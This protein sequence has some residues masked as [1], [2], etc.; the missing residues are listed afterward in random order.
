M[1]LEILLQLV[2]SLRARIS[3]HRATLSQSEALTRYALI[4]PLLRELGW[5]T[6]DPTLVVPEYRSGSGSA[7]YAL[8]SNGRPAMMVEAKKLGTRL[9]DAAGQGIQYCL[10][11]GTPYFT[12]T[13][14]A[15]WEIYET[16]RPVPIDEKRVVEFNLMDPSVAETCLKALALWRP[17]VQSGIVAGGHAPIVDL[18]SA[19]SEPALS[20]SPTPTTIAEPTRPIPEPMNQ[21]IPRPRQTLDVH[22]WQL[23]SDVAPQGTRPDPP[24]EIMFPDGSSTHIKAWADLMVESVRWLASKNFLTVSNCPIYVSNRRYLVSTAPSHQTGNP[25]RT[26]REV[27]S[28]YVEV[29]YQASQCA[30]NAKTIIQHVGQDPAD[31]KVRFA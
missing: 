5:D 28:L 2:E 7:D 17:S 20:V 16:H 24:T 4:D 11:E 29:H 25:M 22:G 1:P 3:A 31:F 9:Q 30:R 6:S 13:D 10:I 23:L 14:G 21:P 8:L 26:P 15:G 18:T 27:N 19:Q 12:L